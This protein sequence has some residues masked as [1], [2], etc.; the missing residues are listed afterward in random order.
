VGVDV[1]SGVAVFVG[2]GVNVNVDVEVDVCVGEGGTCVWVVVGF[3]LAK[4]RDSS[5]VA[6]PLQAT[7][8]IDI[9]RAPAK[10]SRAKRRGEFNIALLH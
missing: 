7:I 10:T 6:T 8:K 2:D 9:S 5:R 4:C 3:D 1:G